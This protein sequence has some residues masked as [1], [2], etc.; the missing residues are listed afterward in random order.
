MRLTGWP[1]AGQN[2]NLGSEHTSATLPVIRPQVRFQHSVCS[3][4]RP[5]LQE[6]VK[7]VGVVP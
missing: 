2:A 3:N 5:S 7:S 4:A 6:W 1:C